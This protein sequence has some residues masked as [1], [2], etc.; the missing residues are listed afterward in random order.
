MKMSQIIVFPR[1][2]KGTGDKAHAGVNMSTHWRKDGADDVVLRADVSKQS[3]PYLEN[4]TGD[5]I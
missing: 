3:H 2:L 1:N 5:D 4:R